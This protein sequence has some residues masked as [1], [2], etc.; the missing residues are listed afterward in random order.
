MRHH[1]SEGQTEQA[2]CLSLV[3]NLIVAFNTEYL[4]RAVAARRAAGVTIDGELL[5]HVWPTMTEHVRFHGL[6]VFDL[7]R[8]LAV[9][10]AAGYRALRPPPGNNHDGSP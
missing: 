6:Y 7:D 1:D 9:L 10:D 3:T 8:E 5:A 4:D 2:L